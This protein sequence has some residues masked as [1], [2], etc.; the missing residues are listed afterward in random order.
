MWCYIIN[1]Y[2]TLV[3]KLAQYTFIGPAVVSFLSNPVR[4]VLS[5]IFYNRRKH[6]CGKHLIQGH[7]TWAPN[8]DHEQLSILITKH[9]VWSSCCIT[10]IVFANTVP[11]HVYVL[12]LLYFRADNIEFKEDWDQ[13]LSLD[14]SIRRWLETGRAEYGDRAHYWKAR[15]G[16]DKEATG[17]GV[18]N[19]RIEVW[20]TWIQI[21]AESLSCVI[22]GKLLLVN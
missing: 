2:W 5:L 17:G 12:P 19:M 4:Q 14:L 3:V 7:T 6:S 10:A 1:D 15:L 13:R 8:L 18:R 9:Y 11:Y 20:H 16:K 22:S 21:Q